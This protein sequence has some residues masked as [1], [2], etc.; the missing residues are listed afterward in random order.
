MNSQRR[1]RLADYIRK[2]H[3]DKLVF[4]ADDIWAEFANKSS[5]NAL[6][7]ENELAKLADIVI[8]VVE[9]PGT[10]AELGAFSI[11]DELR[12][13]LLPIV[14]L[15]YRNT[16]SFI[17]TGPLTWI[18]AD[19]TFKPTIFVSFS[20]ILDAVQELDERLARLHTTGRESGERVENNK[21]SPRHLL[22][23]LC[24]LLAIIGPATE[25][26]CQHYLNAILDGEPAWSIDNLLSLGLAMRVIKHIDA[27]GTPRLYY[28][29]LEHG[30]LQPFLHQRSL[31]L[32]SERARF[33]NVLNNIKESSPFI[34]SMGVLT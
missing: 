6:K 5:S 30:A 7:I 28:R 24:D 8:I 20:V 10:F 14:D 4:Y 2:H 15:Q 17:N 11:S 31:N 1:D 22:F 13:K 32:A 25:N 19:S 16:N 34:R 27:A 9:S 26:Q 29:P 18:D 3:P 12:K 21:L 33:L 23:L